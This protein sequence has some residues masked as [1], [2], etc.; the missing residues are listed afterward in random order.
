MFTI[1][2][3]H[4]GGDEELLQVDFVRYTPAS[5]PPVTSNE[6]SQSPETV[7]VVEHE[8]SGER[9]LTGGTIFVMNEAGKTVARYDIGASP[10]PIVGDGLTDTRPR[11]TGKRA[12]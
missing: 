6:P 1:R 3:I 7:W 2:H 10:V 12:A 9:P 11:G 4:I 8:M 5:K